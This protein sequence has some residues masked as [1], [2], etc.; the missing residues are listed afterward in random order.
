LFS[1]AWILFLYAKTKN[2]KAFVI[3]V[4]GFV[5]SFLLAGPHLIPN[6]ESYLYAARA[7]TDVKLIFSQYLVVPWHV[8]TYIAPDFFGSPASYNFFGKGFYYEK[9]IYIG[10]VGFFL[11]LIA[12]FSRKKSS[13]NWF[14]TLGWLITL[15]LGMSIPTSWFLLYYLHLPIISTIL[16]TRIFLISSFCLS[17]VAAYGWEILEGGKN[18]ISIAIAVFIF[19]AML[20]YATNFAVFT[21]YTHPLDY[22][23]TVSLRNLYLPTFLALVMIFGLLIF[24]VKNK[25]S[26]NIYFG[27]MLLITIVG[28]IYFGQKYFYFSERQFVYPQ[29]VIFTQISKLT[30]LNRFWSFGNGYI[31][32]NFSTYYK[33]QSPEGY[34]SFYIKRFGEFIEASKNKGNYTPSVIRADSQLIA[35]SRLSEIGQ[36]QYLLKAL[37]LLG[38]SIIAA[39]KNVDDE[40]YL[41]SDSTRRFS[42]VWSDGV[43]TLY[44]NN[45]VL[46]RVFLVSNF[47]IIKN[48]KDILPFIYDKK[49][50]L[51]NVVTLEKNP[52]ISSS[53]E[54]PISSVK[55][56]SY[57]N[58]KVIIKT[59]SNK[60]GILFLSDNY[61]PGWQVTIDGRKEE[62][63]RADYSFRGVLVKRGS[64]TVVFEYR[65][66]SL[67]LGFISF[68]FGLLIFVSTLFIMKKRNI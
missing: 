52:G 25:Y 16:P 45:F 13:E 28:I 29:N 33:I 4:L 35:L 5:T 37:D 53:M 59:D 6:F 46:P 36:N 38:V 31:D 64:H 26:K 61:Y 15:S 21:R 10:V 19:F 56:V 14:F 50:N 7:N 44:K 42:I 20:A 40:K 30:G 41:L 60:D 23:A 2:H 24:L 62:V 65:P 48:P 17:I 18:K 8:I 54:E 27:L 32:R 49:T 12:L 63:L 47:N 66:L 3:S 51:R 9:V 34:D 43:Y 57:Q 67:T 11:G 58:E 22:Y 39:H 68:I 55:I 1:F